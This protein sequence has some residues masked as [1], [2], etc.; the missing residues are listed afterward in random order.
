MSKAEESKF[1]ISGGG[2]SL[3]T[4]PLKAQSDMDNLKGNGIAVIRFRAA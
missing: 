3:K 4:K 1:L 2:E